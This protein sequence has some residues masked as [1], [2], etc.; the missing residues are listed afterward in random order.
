LLRIQ[1]DII[2]AVGEQKVVLLTMIDLSAAFDTVNHECLLS[3]LQE[4]GIQDTALRWFHSY[5]TCRQQRINV[6]GTC[7]ESKDL[8]CGVPQGS[9][10]GPILFTVYTSSLGRLIREEQLQY[11]IYADDTSIYLSIKPENLIDGIRQIERCVARVQQ[12]MRKF[13][14][15]MNSDKT[16]FM[17]ISSKR[18]A[19]RITRSPLA[20]EDTLIEPSTSVRSLG[21]TLDHHAAMDIHIQN[22]CRGAYLQLKNIRTLKKYLDRSSLECVI[23]AFVTSR[24]DYCN[25]LLIGLPSSLINRLQMIQNTAARILTNTSRFDHIT[26]VLKSLHWLPVQKRIVY[27]LLLLVYKSVHCLAPSYLQE[28][29]SPYIPSRTLRSS[30]QHLLSV[31]YTSSALIRSRTFSEAGPRLWNSLPYDIRTVPCIELFKS[32]LKT[33]LFKDTFN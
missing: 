5:L 31:P 16:E 23:H 3:T 19:N 12:W 20:I 17:I 6:M 32:K 33:H 21:V 11:H 25:S 28:L 7:S 24:L 9:V 22:V 2:K 30:D 27:K 13:Q 18:L 10:L 4:L 8:T 1:N 15:K 14:L 26:P 29:I